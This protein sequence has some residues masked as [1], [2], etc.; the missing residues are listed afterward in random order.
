MFG[1]NHHVT[2]TGF[3]W[4]SRVPD[5]AFAYEEALGYCVDPANVRDKDGISALVTLCDMV[6]AGHDPVRVLEH[7]SATLGSHVQHN[8]SLRIEPERSAKLRSALLNLTHLGP[9]EVKAGS[10]LAASSTPTTGVM[11][12]LEHPNSAEIR[13]V[14]RPSGTEP[15]TKAYIEAVHASSELASSAAA[16]CAAVLLD[17]SELLG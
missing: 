10:D 17:L 3:K 6:A 15:K 9:F 7:L 16:E 13:L 2:L 8:L 4:L 11:L 12:Q 5:L 14:L 1:A